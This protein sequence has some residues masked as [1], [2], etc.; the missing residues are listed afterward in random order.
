MTCVRPVPTLVPGGLGRGFSPAFLPGTADGPAGSQS[1]LWAGTWS[2]ASVSVFGDWIGSGA[3]AG[4]RAV[5]SRCLA[6]SSFDLVDG[7]DGGGTGAAAL[8][9]SSRPLI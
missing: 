5:P 8:S 6:S 1:R 9:N 2:L 4:L 3:S 7:P